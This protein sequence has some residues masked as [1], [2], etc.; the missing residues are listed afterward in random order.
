VYCDSCGRP[1]EACAGCRRVLD[2][3]R[4]CRHCGRKLRVQVNPVGYVARCFEHGVV[5]EHRGGS[6]PAP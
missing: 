2:P 6:A 5:G 3:P 1:A 4:F